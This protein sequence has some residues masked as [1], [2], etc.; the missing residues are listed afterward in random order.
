VNS[1]RRNFLA[2]GLALPTA[3]LAT[4]TT[5]SSAP[6]QARLPEPA[7][8][9]S[10]QKLGKTGLRPTRVAFGCMITS[11]GSVIEK[12]ADLGINYF[13]T[14]RGYQ[15]GNNERMVGAALKSRRKEV[16]ISSKSHTPSKEKALED[17]ET[18]LKTLGTDY[19][20]IWYLHALGSAEELTPELLEAQQIAKKAGKIRF[21]GVSTHS[22][23]A[24]VID[25]AIKSGVIDVVLLAYNF[26]MDPA[27]EAALGRAKEAGIGLVAMKVMAG[28]FRRAKPGD[29]TQE[30]LKRDGAMVAAL[31]WVLKNPKIDT[32]IPSMTDMEQLD[33]N[34]KAMGTKFSEADEKTLT[35]YLD[36]IGPLYCRMCGKC[37]GTCA[38]GL[39]VADV[40]RFLTYADGY[41][42][43][44][45]GRERFLELPEEV[46]A[47]R[48][49]ECSSCSVTCPYGVRV[50]ERAGR[51]Q[52]LFA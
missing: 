23:Q 13:D 39:P 50:A 16:Y 11:D 45:L 5:Q 27:I 28:G 44:A 46:A 33:A 6:P 3:A 2:A 7:A 43:F 48:C 30:L 47:V 40:L 38:K 29:K 51:A 18:S 25:G 8:G 34:L 21:R 20:D 17:L 9:L 32:T 31:K 24:S 36:R 15:G 19:L 37:E 14:A 41:G 12:A 52:E 26:A 4:T 10:Y 35:A 22:G 1:S 49:G 42:Q